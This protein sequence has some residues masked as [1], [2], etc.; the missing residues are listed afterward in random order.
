MHCKIIEDIGQKYQSA[1]FRYRLSVSSTFFVSVVVPSSTL[2]GM[3]LVPGF[4]ASSGLSTC[5]ILGYPAVA[6]LG[7]TAG[8]EALLHTCTRT[9]FCCYL[10]LFQN[11]ILQHPVMIYM[12]YASGAGAVGTGIMHWWKSSSLTALA[13]KLTSEDSLEATYRYTRCIR[14]SCLPFFL[15]P[16]CAIVA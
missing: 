3:A 11:F 12:P 10:H 16:N 9:Y 14:S 13:T 4:A 2:L 8:D 5:F 6:V 1:L 7:A 15:P